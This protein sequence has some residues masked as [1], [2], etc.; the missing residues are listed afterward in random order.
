MGTRRRAPT[1]P[2]RDLL[3]AIRLRGVRGEAVLQHLATLTEGEPGPVV[4]G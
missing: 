3:D 1:A 2:L 4:H